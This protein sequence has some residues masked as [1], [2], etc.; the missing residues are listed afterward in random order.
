MG[1]AR[2]FG[3]GDSGDGSLGAAGR[4]FHS[5]TYSNPSR[6]QHDA[7]STA[8]TD[9]PTTHSKDPSADVDTFSKCDG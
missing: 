5:E 2:Y 8:D 4:D 6:D 1:G 7:T 9:T 3:G